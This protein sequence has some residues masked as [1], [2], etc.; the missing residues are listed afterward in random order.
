GSEATAWRLPPAPLA[1]SLTF[2]PRVG[3]V[4]QRIEEDFGGHAH[5]G[6]LELVA[7][8]EN[9][10]SIDAILRIADIAVADR[11]PDRIA[12]TAAREPAPALPAAIDGSRAQERDRGIGCETGEHT[13]QSL[14]GLSLQRGASLKWCGRFQLHGPTET[15]KQRRVVRPDFS[16]PGTIAL[17]QTQ[18]L[19]G[20]ITGIGDAVRLSGGHQ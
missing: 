18:R 1:K 2:D 10:R 15:G 14:C 5:C 8:G 19:D 12:V 16:A 20:A 6:D 13:W 17:L 9:A 3:G 4:V 7:A 11:A